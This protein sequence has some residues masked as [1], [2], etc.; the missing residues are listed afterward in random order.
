MAFEGSQPISRS[1]LSLGHI[2]I[3]INVADFYFPVSLHRPNFDLLQHEA[4]VRNMPLHSGS[5]TFTKAL[6]HV[7]FVTTRMTIAMTLP[8]TIAGPNG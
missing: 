8:L 3:I 7:G 1:F 5:V 2:D 4:S 6:L